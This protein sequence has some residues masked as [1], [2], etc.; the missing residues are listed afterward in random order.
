MS[1]MKIFASRIT[2]H[3]SIEYKEEFYNSLVG[4]DLWLLCRQF[5]GSCS[6][7]D[8][9]FKF[10]KSEYNEPDESMYYEVLTYNTYYN[11]IDCGYSI[12]S[13]LI[14]PKFPIELLTTDEL[15]EKC[16]RYE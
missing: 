6:Y 9:W 13:Y 10:V 11:V 8:E 3:S 2:E 5:D 16:S 12:W 15:K 1:F 14:H 7:Y 4:K